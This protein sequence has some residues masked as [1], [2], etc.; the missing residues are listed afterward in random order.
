MQLDIAEWFRVTIRA[1]FSDVEELQRQ[2]KQALAKHRTELA[3]MQD[4]L[5]NGYLSR[6]IEETAFNAKTAELKRQATEVEESLDRANNYD[7]DAPVR[8]LALFDFSQRIAELWEGSNSEVKREILEC[9]SLNRTVSDVSLCLTKRKPFDFLA[10]R[11]FLKDGRG[12]R[13]RTGDLLN[14][15]QTR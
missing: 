2:R 5:L 14:P 6:A 12:G 4:R 7:P 10:E 15:I 9:V 1:V 8:A 13:I 11:P 3:G